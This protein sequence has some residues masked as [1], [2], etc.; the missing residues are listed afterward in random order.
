MQKR[1]KNW[2]KHFRKKVIMIIMTLMVMLLSLGNLYK[3]VYTNLPS[4]RENVSFLIVGSLPLLAMFSLIY[5]TYTLMR[6]MFEPI[7]YMT[8]AEGI[9]SLDLQ[10]LSLIHI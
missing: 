5:L 10:V 6:Q 9:G 7:K 4:I 3:F 1:Q 8:H 2:M